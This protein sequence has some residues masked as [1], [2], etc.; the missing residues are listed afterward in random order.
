MRDKQLY[1]VAFCPSMN[2]CWWQF[3][4]LV[5]LLCLCLCPVSLIRQSKSGLFCKG[6]FFV[7]LCLKLFT[8]LINLTVDVLFVVAHFHKG[9]TDLP[10]KCFQTSV[11]WS[12]L[13][14][15]PFT[16]G[17]KPS[18]APDMPSRG[19]FGNIN[20][21]QK[22]SRNDGTNARYRPHPSPYGVCSAIRIQCASDLFLKDFSLLK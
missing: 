8:L 11:P 14:L 22:P 15:L 17:V 21:C 19:G 18:I 13:P 10:A 3:A 2:V 9:L 4:L 1:S 5:M 12:L 20:M 7:A 6:T 16:G